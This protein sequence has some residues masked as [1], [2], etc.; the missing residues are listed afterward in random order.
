MGARTQ[1]VKRAL[2]VA[3]VARRTKLLRVLR[4]VGVGGQRPATRDGARAFREALEEPGTTYIKLGQKEGRPHYR[5]P[6]L[7][8]PE[9]A[10]SASCDII[11]SL[12]KQK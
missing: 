1:R 11:A 6:A 5:S 12:Q 4:E 3:R 10:D 8:A 7:P 9:V 2:H